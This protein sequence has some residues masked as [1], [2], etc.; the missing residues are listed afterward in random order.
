[1]EVTSLL[2][3]NLKR[4]SALLKCTVLET[5]LGMR[6][7]RILNFTNELLYVRYS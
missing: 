4:I 1:M 7:F 3:S 2:R 5:N 6:H